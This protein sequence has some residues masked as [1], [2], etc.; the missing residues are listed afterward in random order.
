MDY[1]LVRVFIICDLNPIILEP[2]VFFYIISS[3][4]TSQNRQIIYLL[5]NLTHQPMEP[6]IV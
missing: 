1:I 6:Q 2:H 5:K 4:C 3:L